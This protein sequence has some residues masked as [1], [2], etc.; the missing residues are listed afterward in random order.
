MH[1][2]IVGF[3]MSRLMYPLLIER[4]LEK[5]TC[6]CKG[7]SFDVNYFKVLGPDFLSVLLFIVVLS[8]R[9][10]SELEIF[11]S[12]K[13]FKPVNCLSCMLCVDKYLPKSLPMAVF[14]HIHCNY[15]TKHM[16]LLL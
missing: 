5:S 3:V 10:G 13:V 7:T 8:V 15:H 2:H 14:K 11:R 6:T 1:S 12:I 4:K 16:Q 9:L